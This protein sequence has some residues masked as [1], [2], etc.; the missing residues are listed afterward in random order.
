[1]FVVITLPYREGGVASIVRNIIN[2]IEREDLFIQVILLKNLKD[3]QAFLPENIKADRIDV[4]E[5]LSIENKYS[6]Y[7]RLCN[8]FVSDLIISNDELSVIAINTMKLNYKII[9]ICHTSYE[10]EFYFLKKYETTIDNIITVSLFNKEKIDRLLQKQETA[11]VHHP[12]PDIWKIRNRNKNNKLKIIFVGR[13]YKDKGIFNLFLIDSLLKSKGIIVEW[14]FVGFGPHEKDFKNQFKEVKNVTW[15]GK[16]SNKNLANIYQNQDIFILPSYSEGF[17]V[18][19]IEAM[20]SGLIPLVSDL[21]GGIPEVVKDGET[22]YLFPINQP[23]LYAEKIEYLSYNREK[24]E[25]LSLNA[26]KIVTEKF[27]PYT[28][29][30]KYKTLIEKVYNAPKKNKVFVKDKFGVLDKMFIPNFLVKFIRKII[31]K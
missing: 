28:Q 8:L 14:T 23:D 20:K 13:F 16:M 31:S 5:Y 3:P 10:S 19:L 2:Y 26:L 29:A 11:V 18:T 21:P 22:G 9:Y 25:E 15:I 7:K 4:F 17:P 24:L 12:I 1:M 6:V 27:D 30:A